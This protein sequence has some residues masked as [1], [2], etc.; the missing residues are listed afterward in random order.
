MRL[1]YCGPNTVNHYF[2]EGPSVR[3][4]ACRD[5][6]FIEMADLVIRVFMVVVPLS[7]ILASYIHI[8]LAI[9]KIKSTQGRCKAF[10]TC[11]SPLTVVTLFYA[12][13][14]FIYV[15]PNSYSPE[16]GKQISFFYSVFMALLNP[17][18]YILRNKDIKQPFLKMMGHS[19]VA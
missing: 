11:A 2:C 14:T 17:V 12:L 1:P 18:V 6:H 3:S 15:R 9:L 8:A 5:T 13:V 16:L 10:W 7:L 4:L 19:R